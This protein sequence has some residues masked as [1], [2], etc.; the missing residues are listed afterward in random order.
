M[1]V[2]SVCMEQGQEI[3]L[4]KILFS[5]RQLKPKIKNRIGPQSSIDWLPHGDASSNSP[6]LVCVPLLKPREPE[7]WFIK[8]THLSIA[9]FGCWH[10]VDRGG[11][12]RGCQG[13]EE[14]MCRSEMYAK[15]TQRNEMYEEGSFCGTA[16]H[17]VQ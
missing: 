6:P 2:Q 14:G 4:Y 12:E 3:Y 15:C 5:P 16:E 8:R 7:C 13:G 17:V 11:S 1:Y 10:S 9:P